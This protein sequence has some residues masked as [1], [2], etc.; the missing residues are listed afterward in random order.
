MDWHPPK[1]LQYGSHRASASNRRGGGPQTSRV[2]KHDKGI[3][4]M[5]MMSDR[6]ELMCGGDA[7]VNWYDDWNRDEETLEEYEGRK[8][9]EECVEDVGWK[10][11][12]DE[13]K[14]AGKA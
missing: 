5:D 1:Q 13:K 6:E 7:D 2:F 9:W 10:V 8:G 4:K 11:W 3:A 12:H 14:K